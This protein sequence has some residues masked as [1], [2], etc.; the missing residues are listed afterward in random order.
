VLVKRF[1]LV[2]D[3]DDIQVL[4]VNNKYNY[5]VDY[6]RKTITGKN[7]L[8]ITEDYRYNS[9]MINMVNVDHSFEYE[10]N[11]DLLTQEQFIFA[12]SLKQYAISSALKWKELYAVSSRSLEM[13]QQENRKQKSTLHTITEELSS[14][15]ETISG[16]S[17]ELQKREQTIKERN[18]WLQKLS[19]ENKLQEKKYEVKVEIER[20]LE[21]NIRQQIEF[22][23]LQQRQ[24]DSSASEQLLYCLDYSPPYC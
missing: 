15:E 9:S 19:E 17:K 5:D 11:E 1:S 13:T 3:I 12:P 23:N 20:E 14:K 21:A 10:I 16:Q 2:K 22:I 24:I 4:Y 7:I 18:E 8:L 6:I